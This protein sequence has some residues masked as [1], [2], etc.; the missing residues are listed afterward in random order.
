MLQNDTELFLIVDDFDSKKL[1]ISS[2]TFLISTPNH[3]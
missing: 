3:F 2:H 1:A